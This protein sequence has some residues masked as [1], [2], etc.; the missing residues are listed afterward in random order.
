MSRYNSVEEA[1]KAI[2]GISTPILGGLVSFNNGQKDL[3]EYRIVRIESQCE[4]VHVEDR[5]V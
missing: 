5:R 4:V 3:F 1:K 2:A